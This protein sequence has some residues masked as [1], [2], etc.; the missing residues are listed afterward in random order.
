MHRIGIIVNPSS[1]RDI[2]RLLSRASVFPTGEKISI[3]LRLLAGLGATGVAEALLMPDAAGIAELREATTAGI[4][5]GLLVGGRVPRDLALRRNCCG[6]AA[7]T[8][9]RSPWWTSAWPA[10]GSW[11][12]ARSGSPAT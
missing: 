12:P 2:R 8:A 6:C 11:A 10:S 1:G 5:L 7:A 4:A 3:V 9:R